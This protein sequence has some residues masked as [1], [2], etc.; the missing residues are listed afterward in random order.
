M[1]TV[2]RKKLME[3]IRSFPAFSYTNRAL[4]ELREFLP[5]DHFFFPMG[6][7]DYG[8]IPVSAILSTFPDLHRILDND[9]PFV[10]TDDTGY[11][12]TMQLK[13]L[14]APALWGWAVLKL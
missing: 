11:Q 6:R 8:P 14:I 1:I 12:E 3:L 9:E 10:L 7:V 5:N 13:L 4:R 2:N